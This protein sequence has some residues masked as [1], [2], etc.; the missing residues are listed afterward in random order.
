MTVASCGEGGR[1]EG[2]LATDQADVRVALE[3]ARRAFRA[4]FRVVERDLGPLLPLISAVGRDDAERRGRA[5]ARL[6]ALAAR[7]EAEHSVPGALLAPLAARLEG[8]GDGA[9]ARLHRAL[10]DYLIAVGMFR[11]AAALSAAT[12]VPPGLCA[13]AAAI[14]GALLARDAGPALAWCAE[15]RAALRRAESPLEF[16]VRRLEFVELARARRLSYACAYAR[17]HLAAYAPGHVLEVQQALALLALAPACA[18][19]AHA[20][21]YDGGRWADAARHFCGELRAL[22]G[23]PAQPELVSLVHAGLA[24]LRTRQCGVCA[25]SGGAIGEAAGVCGSLLARPEASMS[26]SASPGSPHQAGS[27][28][29]GSPAGA[30]LAPSASAMDAASAGGRG[31][32]AADLR[33]PHPTPN[34]AAGPPAGQ[35]APGASTTTLPGGKPGLAIPEGTEKHTANVNCPACAPPLAAVARRVPHAHHATSVL[36]CP[37]SGAP[38]DADNAPVALPSGAVVS[39]AAAEG[40][41]AAHGGR[42]PCPLTGT[43]YA[44]SSVRRL[45]IS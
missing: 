15:N 33:I 41:A 25:D 35:S 7:L 14:H 20:W 36:V 22:H 26:P 37:A 3:G 1:P 13:E 18:G 44:L 45:Y 11:G 42:V 32:G 27:L 23:L 31:A 5:A 9:R 17:T 28:P 24:A 2:V 39:R 21:L 16:L 4:H 34:A 10:H 30:V 8:A 38:M 12:G 19:G 6:R 43:L 29:Q 40:L